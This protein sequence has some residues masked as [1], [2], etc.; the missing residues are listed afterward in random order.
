MVMGD[1]MV[2][3]GWN[4]GWLAPQV[5]FEPLLLSYI[6]DPLTKA[7]SRTSP[8]CAEEGAREWNY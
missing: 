1:H 7:K 4:S 6:Q 3:Q 8:K 2:C 5:L